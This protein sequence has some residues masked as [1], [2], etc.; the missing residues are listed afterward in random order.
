ML[1]IEHNVFTIRLHVI[2]ENKECYL[3]S[4][5]CISVKYGVA[6]ELGDMW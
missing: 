4:I 6:F 5:K 1:F 2:V 3:L